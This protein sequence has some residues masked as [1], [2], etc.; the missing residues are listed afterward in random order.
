MM[1]NKV[2]NYKKGKEGEEIA[3]KFLEQKGFRLI[4]SNYNNKLGEIDL[5]MSNKEVLVFVEVKLKVGDKFGSPEEM[6]SK[7]KL[8]R[9]RR[10]AESFLMLNPEI[11]R[12]FLKYRLDAVCIVLNE[13]KTV[14]RINHYENLYD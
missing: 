10:I 7:Y 5:I 2:K 12:N 8:N 4:E 13:D 11:K 3:K 6:I 9:I 1:S 14:T